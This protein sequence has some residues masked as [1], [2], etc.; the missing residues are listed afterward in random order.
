VSSE[1]T[2]FLGGA[3]IVVALLSIAAL[4][5][6]LSLVFTVKH[7]LRY[8]AGRA[9]D[10]VVQAGERQVM[11]GVG[12]VAK[13]VAEEVRKHDPKRLEADVTRLAEQRQGNLAVADVMA[14]LQL[15]QFQAQ[16][17]LA[18]LVRQR[19]CTIQPG[20]LG[21]RY[22]FEAF[23]PRQQVH[24]CPFC[25]TQFAQPSDHNN[26]PNCGGKIENQ[27]VLKA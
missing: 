18:R 1:W 26:C 21:T 16:E 5:G 12:Q 9:V 15:S 23:L 20:P 27:T 22:L 13:G 8:V 3:A 11:K 10:R 6:F 14:A 2:S 19:V 24:R 4:V 7:L 25:E 17:A